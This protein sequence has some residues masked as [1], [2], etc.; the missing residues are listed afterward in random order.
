V[1]PRC[2]ARDVNTIRIWRG[3]EIGGGLMRPQEKTRATEQRVRYSTYGPQ[4]IK[5]D[6]RQLA[7]NDFDEGGRVAQE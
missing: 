6:G 4:G 7:E 3:V 1:L 5:A 2:V